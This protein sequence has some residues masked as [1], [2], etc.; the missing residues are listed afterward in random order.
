MTRGGHL[1]STPLA[2]FFILIAAMIVC[3]MSFSAAGL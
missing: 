1:G 2:N 3:I